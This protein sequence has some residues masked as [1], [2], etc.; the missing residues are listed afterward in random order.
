MDS[1]S[2]S[3]RATAR[4]RG[5]PLIRLADELGMSPTQI[6]NRVHRVVP[7]TLPEAVQASKALGMTL[8]EFAAYFPADG[9]GA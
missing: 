4:A 1:A 7:W 6:S 2:M 3:F 8:P 5:W 9:K